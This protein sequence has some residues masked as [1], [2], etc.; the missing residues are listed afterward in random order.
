VPF[1]NNLAERDLRMTKVQQKISGCF[2][3]MAGAKHFCRIRGY[4]STL[5]KQGQDVLLALRSTF[6]GSPLYPAFST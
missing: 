2:R 3:N 6:S 1:D 5:R 4:I